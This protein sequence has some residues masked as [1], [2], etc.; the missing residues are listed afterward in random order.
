MSHEPTTSVIDTL[1]AQLIK[2]HITS[3]KS[4]KT[5]PH[6]QKWL[7]NERYNIR[8]YAAEYG[9]INA[10]RKLKTD[11]PKLSESTVRSFKKKYYEEL[12]RHT[13]EDLEASQRLRKY[14]RQAGPYY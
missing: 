10:L 9:N 5:K 6:Y 8:K 12:S 11:F 3:A 13:K 7:E 2:H 1:D 4:V 14:S